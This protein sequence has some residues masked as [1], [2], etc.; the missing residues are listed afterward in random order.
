MQF[1][2]CDAGIIRDTGTA[3]GR[4]VFASRDITAGEIVEACPV[5]PFS[6]E[7]DDMPKVLQR[8][9]FDWGYLTD[10]PTMSCFALGWGGMYNHANPAN[11][12]YSGVADSLCLTFTAAR[13]IRAG[14]E[15]T[16]NYNGSKGDV[17][18]DKDDWFEDTGVALL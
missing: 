2:V 1:I 7:W 13:D 5:I 6:M 8:V 18:S 3:K 11:L 16:I 17:V 15:L 4:G 12:R 10:G 14:E 9:A